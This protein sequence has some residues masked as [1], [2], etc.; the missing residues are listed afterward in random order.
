[1][2]NSQKGSSLLI[3]LLILLIIGGTV[4][5]FSQDNQTGEQNVEEDFV[6]GGAW[7]FE[8]TAGSPN[9][10][11]ITTPVW[12][13]TLNINKEETGGTLDIDGYQTINRFNVK[14]V[15]MNDSANVIFD[16]YANENIGDEF[17]NGDVLLVVLPTSSK[18]LSVVWEKLKPN[19]EKSLTD[20]FFVK[21]Q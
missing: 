11:G 9:A 4:Y 2:K 8:E 3:A 19:S 13:Y 20:I 10:N 6:M 7:K 1:M 21:I 17:K 15:K 16:S 5:Y 12:E 14:I 18:D